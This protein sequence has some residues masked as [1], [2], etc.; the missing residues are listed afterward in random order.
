MNR[1]N[2]IRAANF[3]TAKVNGKRDPDQ[4]NR[5][6]IYFR[7]LNTLPQVRM[8]LG[9]FLNKPQKKLA[10]ESWPKGNKFHLVMRTEEKG[11][12]VNLTTQLLV[13]AFDDA[14]DVAVIISND[15][16]LKIRDIRCP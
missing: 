4:P 5:Q 1:N 15:G 6:Q 8:H 3:F 11:S 7:A 12:D 14:F 10:V 16:D 2:E 13:D 9:H